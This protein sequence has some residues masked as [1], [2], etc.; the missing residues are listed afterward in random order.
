MVNAARVFL[1]E[2]LTLMSP[3]FW[4]PKCLPRLL[5]GDWMRPRRFQAEFPGDFLGSKFGGRFNDRSEWITHQACVFT[6][7]VIDAPK[8]VA[9][10]R[11]RNCARLHVRSSSH[12]E[13]VVVYQLHNMRAQSV[14][15]PACG[16]GKDAIQPEERSGIL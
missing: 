3:L 14:Y 5:G 8:L 16:H 12:I 6:V 1:R 2:L 10:L 13:T 15:C 4:K 11:Y 9:R 7:S